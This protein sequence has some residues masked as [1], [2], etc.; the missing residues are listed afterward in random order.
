M[1]VA[2]RPADFARDDAT[3]LEQGGWLIGTRIF[4]QNPRKLITQAEQEM[5]RIWLACR[6]GGIGGA[7]LLPDRGGVWDQ[8]A[9]MTDAL[10][11]MDDEAA[12]Q[13][14]LHKPATGDDG[15]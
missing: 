15:A 6:P 12:R 10:S 2:M 9:T 7:R 4:K 14:K 8:A 13:Q 1:T 11:I 3:A 5:V